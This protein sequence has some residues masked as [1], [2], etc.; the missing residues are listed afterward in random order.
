LIAVGIKSRKNSRAWCQA[1]DGDAPA[2]LLQLLEKELAKVEAVDLKKGPAGFA[3]E[4]NLFGPKPEKYPEFP[5]SWVDA[6]KK[7][8]TK[9]ILPPDD[10]FKT[11]WPD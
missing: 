8:E 7:S 11:I 4:V 6:A 3:M 10:L 9:L 1:V 5:Q 2:E